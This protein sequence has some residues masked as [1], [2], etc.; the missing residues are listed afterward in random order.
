MIF[1][2]RIY[3]RMGS[4]CL[5]RSAPGWDRCHELFGVRIELV[6]RATRCVITAGPFKSRRLVGV[7]DSPE[8]G[9]SETAAQQLDASA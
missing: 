4:T 7:G 2:S 3:V 1:G 5:R 8:S 9:W 6:V